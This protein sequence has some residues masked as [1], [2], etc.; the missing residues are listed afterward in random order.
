MDTYCIKPINT[1]GRALLIA[2]DEIITPAIQIA[3]RLHIFYTFYRE[4]AKTGADKKKRTSHSTDITALQR[5]LARKIEY[6]KAS[7]IELL[8]SGSGVRVPG[9]VP[10]LI[11]AR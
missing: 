11:A 4:S 9:G 1:N 5:E 2:T 3:E 7:G 6:R 10:S 8:I